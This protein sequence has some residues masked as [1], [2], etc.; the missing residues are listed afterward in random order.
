MI[1]EAKIHIGLDKT[2]T[3][4]I[5]SFCAANEQIIFQNTGWLY[6]P[7]GR[8]Y[9][10]HMEIAEQ[11]GVSCD[12]PIS[13]GLPS[14][15][16]ITDEHECSKTFLSSEHF[17]FRANDENLA[18]LANHFRGFEVEIVVYYREPAAWFLSLYS[19]TVKW[20]N[21]LTFNQ[22]FDQNSWRLNFTRFHNFWTNAFGENNI[23]VMN[24]E[25]EKSELIPGFLN[26]ITDSNF[27]SSMAT[28]SQPVVRNLAINL[29]DIHVLQTTN[30]ALQHSDWRD[31][32]DLFGH[33]NDV[34]RTRPDLIDQAIV[35]SYK[36]VYDAS[37]LELI[38]STNDAFR[39][40]L[41]K[42]NL[43]EYVIREDEKPAQSEAIKKQYYQEIARISNVLL[44]SY[45]QTE[46]FKKL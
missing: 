7:A 41:P 1:R 3:T 2:G 33:Y 9:D 45:Q 15:S 25:D 13:H 28:E 22:F 5:Q 27:G 44:E 17:S 21:Q 14:P 36:N 32:R 35:G 10:H 29:F 8:K 30:K 37:Q 40:R 39:N 26:V 38:K 31:G 43:P 6:Y 23:Q 16:Q 42:H 4:S 20:G 24:Y 18:R 46:R 19:E 11:V 12:P 34:K